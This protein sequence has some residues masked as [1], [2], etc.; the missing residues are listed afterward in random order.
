MSTHNC[1]RND[2]ID[3]LLKDMTELRSDVK[4][5]LEFKNKAMGIIMATTVVC[6]VIAFA[7][8][9]FF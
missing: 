3:I 2:A 7:I 1:Q 4:S 6:N 8:S 9:K 5:L